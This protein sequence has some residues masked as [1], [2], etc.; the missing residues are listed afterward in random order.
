MYLSFTL[1]AA[2]RAFDECPPD[3]S[4]AD[5]ALDRRHAQGM[6]HRVGGG[7]RRVGDRHDDRIVV[8]RHAA[9][10]KLQEGQLA[11]KHRTRQINAA[12]VK[13]AGDIGEVDPFEETVGRSFARR[14]SLAL[15]FSVPDQNHLAGFEK[16]DVL[17]T[18][19][20]ERHALARCSEQHA[21]GGVAER[22]NALGIAKNDHVAHRVQVDNVVSAI[23]LGD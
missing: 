21:V 19:I 20:G 16:L 8:D 23:K 15:D 9:L 7:L 10:L 2:I 18:K 12:V 17:E 13:R 3:G 5:Q 4:V 14:K 11:A 6:G 1:I 22:P